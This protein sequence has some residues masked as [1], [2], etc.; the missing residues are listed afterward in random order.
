MPFVEISDVWLIYVTDVGS[1]R[2]RDLHKELSALRV[3]LENVT[4]MSTASNMSQVM[5]RVM[6]LMHHT[7]NN[8]I[9]I[10]RQHHVISVSSSVVFLFVVAVVYATASLS[11][12]LWGAVSLSPA[13]QLRLDSSKGSSAW[14]SHTCGTSEERLQVW[15]QSPTLRQQPVWQGEQHQTLTS[16]RDRWESRTFFTKKKGLWCYH[17]QSL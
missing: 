12:R 11:W 17:G 2:L 14:P 13:G 1:T 10:W 4:V 8:C 3:S 7:L 6:Q 9:L 16:T 5:W 15:V